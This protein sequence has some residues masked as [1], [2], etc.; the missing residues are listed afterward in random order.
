M[1]R[2][3][4]CDDEVCVEGCFCPNNTLLNTDGNCVKLDQCSCVHDNTYYQ[5]GSKVK[6]GCQICQCINAKFVCNEIAPECQPKCD[7]ST[8]F[9][10]RTTKECI[11]KE[12]ICVSIHI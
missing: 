9:M 10:C 1:N 11:P 12:W 4:Q 5:A 8:K 3:Y 7:N 2:D 6:Q